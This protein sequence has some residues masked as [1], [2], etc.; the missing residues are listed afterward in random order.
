MT[1]CDKFYKEILYNFSTAI[2]NYCNN[3]SMPSP[4]NLKRKNKIIGLNK[5]S[6]R[7]NRNYFVFKSYS[8]SDVKYIYLWRKERNL[9]NTD[10]Q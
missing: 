4:N 9:Y 6:I 1:L 8:F 2:C 10:A 5:K 7:N 3:I